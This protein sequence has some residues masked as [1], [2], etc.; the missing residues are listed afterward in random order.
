MTQEIRVTLTLEV[1]A[2]QSKEDV[3]SFVTNAISKRAI[4][5][6]IEGKPYY[7]LARIDKIEEEAEIYGNK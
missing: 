4:Q 2:S 1:D 7:S 3:T 6:R 5:H